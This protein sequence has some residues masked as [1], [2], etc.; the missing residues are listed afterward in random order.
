MTKE[1]QLQIV[2]KQLFDQIS[3]IPQ[4][5][6]YHHNLKIDHLRNSVL[7]FGPVETV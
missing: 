4:S 5:N 7:K 3:F 2:V 6:Y 1:K